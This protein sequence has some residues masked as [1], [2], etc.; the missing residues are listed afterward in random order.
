MPSLKTVTVKKYGYV[1]DNDS[2]YEPA[3]LSGKMVKVAIGYTTTKR[4]EPEH[5]AMPSAPLCLHP[6]SRVTQSSTVETYGAYHTLCEPVNHPGWW[7]YGKGSSEASWA[8][9]TPPEVREDAWV[10]PL[11]NRIKAIDISLGETVFEYRETAA[12]F[13]RAAHR[14]WD[15]IKWAKHPLRRR[16]RYRGLGSWTLNDISNDFLAAS[17][18]VFPLINVASASYF[19]LMDMLND[20]SFFVLKK[21]EVN[22]QDERTVSGRVVKEAHDLEQ[23]T[24]R[25]VK[26]KVVAYVKYLPGKCGGFTMDN[27]LSVMYQLTRFSFVLDWF[28]GIGEVLMSL[29]AATGV[30][31]VTGTVTVKY[32]TTWKCK[33]V[34][35]GA[36]L[37]GGNHYPQLVRY[38]ADV[39]NRRDE[40]SWRRDVL[41]GIPAPT[42][43]V[44]KKSQSY[45]QL[46]LAVALLHQARSSL[47]E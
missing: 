34:P 21:V 1:G 8:L 14:I 30:A 38:Y 24:R 32:S 33:V 47:P 7:N 36:V 43:P 27:P 19:Q 25:S 39:Q 16:G 15:L 20:P 45:Y 29:D 4:L 37:G 13:A 28:I 9:L 11:R 23:Q 12:L 26:C 42:F 31:G 18:G 22:A 2:A 44:W 17:F 3:H 6:T 41:T 35:T 40:K 5:R 10:T 46:A